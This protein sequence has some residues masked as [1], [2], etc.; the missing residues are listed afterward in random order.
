MTLRSADDVLAAVRV[1]LGFEPHDSLVM[2][3]VGGRYP[4]QARVDLPGDPSHADFEQALDELADQLLEPLSRLDARSVLLV[5]YTDH[6]RLGRRSLRGLVRRL[7]A[8][9]TSVAD[10]LRADGRR[11]YP[12]DDDRSGLTVTG[13]Q[14]DVDAHPF[15][16]AAV[17]EG[18]VV[19]GCRDDVAATMRPDPAMVAEVEGARPQPRASARWVQ[20]Q[21]ARHAGSG[22]TPSA[23]D[24]ARLLEGIAVTDVREAVWTGADRST[25]PAAVEFWTDLVR[26]APDDLVA[27]AAAVLAFQSWLSGDGARAW[28]AV[29][30]ALETDP[31]QGLARLV[32][33]LLEAA[34]PPHEWE[35]TRD[36]LGFAS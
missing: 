7:T 11:W 25:A 3:T 16:V 35:S 1:V 30:R 29:D 12:L 20:A 4:L 24:A 2:I 5:A 17:V 15:V 21:A 33:D 6:E 23:D 19:H 9:G 22:T 27:D 32:G 14:Y 13:V 26:R 36:A 10:A 18:R 31:E 28:C 8:A 34:F